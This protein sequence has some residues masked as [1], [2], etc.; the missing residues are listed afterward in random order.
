[1]KLVALV[2]LLAITGCSSSSSSAPFR[3][4]NDEQWPVGTEVELEPGIPL[5]F[6]RSTVEGEARLAATARAHLA[7]F[8]QDWGRPVPPVSIGV[9]YSRS[10]KRC[11]RDD[12]PHVGCYCLTG[13]GRASILVVLG[14]RGE[15]PAL[16]HELGHHVLTG[17]DPEH[18]DPRWPAI[19]RQ[20]DA[21]A[22]ELRARP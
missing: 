21:F 18:K 8:R 11:V 1:M 14:E 20:G 17:P 3:N 19:E 2:A 5:T 4:T 15:L 6:P 12:V 9:L 10:F 13:S 16:T 22:E 7:R